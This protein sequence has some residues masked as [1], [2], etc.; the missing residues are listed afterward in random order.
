MLWVD[1]KEKIPTRYSQEVKTQKKKCNGKL[2]GNERK[3]MNIGKKVN[4]K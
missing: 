3:L 1:A 4:T 2:Y